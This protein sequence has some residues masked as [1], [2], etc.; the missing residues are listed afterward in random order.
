MMNSLF[1]QKVWLVWQD[2]A[3]PTSA[4]TGKRKGWQQNL[5]T[6]SEAKQFVCDNPGYRIGIMFNKECGYIGLDFDSAIDPFAGVAKWARPYQE[7]LKAQGVFMEKSVSGTGFKAIIKTDEQIQRG[8]FIQDAEKTGD[9]IPQIEVYNTKYFALTSPVLELEAAT[10]GTWGPEQVARFSEML[11]ESI[12][13]TEKTEAPAPQ[14]SGDVS[15]EKLG[16]ALGVLDATKY[17]DRESWMRIMSIAHHAT[18]GSEEGLQ[19]FIEWSA[20]D[21]ANFTDGYAEGQWGTLNSNRPNALTFG[22]LVNEFSPEQKLEFYGEPEPQPQFEVLEAPKAKVADEYNDAGIADM[23]YRDYQSK[24]AYVTESKAWYAYDGRKWYRAE[25]RTVKGA[26][27]TFI[28]RGNISPKIKGNDAA[29]IVEKLQSS[30]AASAIQQLVLADA[31]WTISVN[32]L[33]NQPHKFNVQNGTVNLETMTLEPHNPADYISQVAGSDYIEGAKCSLWLKVLSDVFAG[34]QEV[35]RFVQQVF[36][37]SLLGYNGEEIFPI[38]HGSG[39]NGKSTVIETIAA[40][41]GDYS[42]VTTSDLLD[43]KKGLHPTYLAAIVGKRFVL[44]DEMAKDVDLNESQVKKLASTDMMNARVMRGDVFTFKPSH[45]PW[46]STN[47]IPQVDGTDDGIWRRI[48]LIPFTV[49][50]RDVQDSTIK[51]RLLGEL[52]GVLL[53]AMEGLKDYYANQGFIEPEAVRLATENYR[54]DEDDFGSWW[55]SNLVESNEPTQWVSMSNF[56]SIYNTHHKNHLRSNR[57]AAREVRSH[58]YKVDKLH[59]RERK[60]ETVIVGWK[61]KPRA[62]GSIE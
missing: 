56:I 45:M 52:P 46:L 49:S 50:L 11:G 48:R 7:I 35:I 17:A 14:N 43:A 2:K 51:D 33:D 9:H 4:L 40:M 25:A 6:F 8:T 16:R 39:C 53:W 28:R 42:T 61:L 38:G 32:D 59:T 44:V 23:F 21:E 1:N 27:N 34:N 29:K 47:H 55:E 5:S 22:S 58:G 31:R 13:T 12:A 18:G 26:V 30:S 36:G 24:L 54:Q 62:L 60:N 19:A 3:A 37:Y 20:T 10:T 57:R 15:A 41:F